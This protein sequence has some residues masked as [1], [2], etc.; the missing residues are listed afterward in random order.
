MA[1]NRR[2]YGLKWSDEYTQ[3]GIEL[4]FIKNGGYLRVAGAQYGC[5]LFTH[6]RNAMS[7][8]WPKD[9]HHRWS[10]LILQSYCDN[11]IIAITGSSDS[12]KTYTMSKIALVD[13]WAAPDDTLWLVST[14][15]GR[16]S[17]LRVWG[18]IKDLFNMARDHH[19]TLAGNPLD[20]LKTITTDEV[21]EGSARSLRRGLIVVP[22]KTGGTQSGLAPYIG[23]KAKRLRHLGDEVAVMNEAFLNAYANWYGKE[24]FRGMMAGNFMETDDPLGIAL[25]PINGWESWEDTGKTQTWRTRFY[26]ALGIALDG[27]DSPNF[28]FPLV[29]GRNKYPYMIGQKKLDGIAQTKGT[30]CWEWYSQCVGK[31]VKGMDIWRVLSKDFCEKHHASDDA[32][33]HSTKTKL[34]SLDPAYGMGDRCVGRLL[35]F[36]N[37]IDG[38]QIIEAGTPEVIPIRVNTGLDPEEQIAMYVFNR[39]AELDVMPQNIFYDSFGRGTLGFQFS[40]LFGRLCPVPVDSGAQPT[41]R[42][43]RFDLFKEETNPLTGRVEKRLILC[44]EYYSKF[45]TEMWF[46]VRE[47]IE[48]EQVRNLDADTI[49]EGCQRKFTRNKSNKIEIETKEDFKSRLKGR[50]PDLMDNFAIG[51]EGARR[52]GFQIRRIEASTSVKQQKNWVREL[53]EKHRA[54]VMAKTLRC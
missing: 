12:G 38:N 6:M 15:E 3:L 22:C 37:D 30:D 2:K 23:I 16:G 19:P 8:C 27:R 34:Y 40:K 54:M 33:W 42:P 43:V 52:L 14:T 36:G 46:S 32:A 45:V 21:E 35:S 17:E 47:A 50:S 44:D 31:P 4:T 13:Y 26:G 10:D 11:E 1:D 5:G 20:Y 48:S 51:I 39:C 24:D 7:L 29:D 18:C 25:E 49:R 28:D 9:D 41:K 53:A